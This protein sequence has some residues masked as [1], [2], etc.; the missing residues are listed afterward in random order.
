MAFRGHVLITDFSYG[1]VS[2]RWQSRVEGGQ[3]ETE[4]GADIALSDVYQHGCREMTNMLI[5]P[6]GGAIKRLGF[7]QAATPDATFDDVDN[8]GDD[9]RLTR[10]QSTPADF[11][12]VFKDQEVIIYETDQGYPWTVSQTVALPYLLT[13]LAQL[14]FVQIRESLIL[15]QP[16]FRPR[17][18]TLLDNGTFVLK[19]TDDRFVPPLFSYRDEFSP[20]L[21]AVTFHVVFTITKNRFLIIDVSGVPT[22]SNTTIVSTDISFTTKQLTDALTNTPSVNPSSV[23]VVYSGVNLEWDITYEFFST[24]GNGTGTLN[25]GIQNPGETEDAVVTLTT[26]GASGGEDLWSGPFLVS[27]N[28]VFYQCLQPHRSTSANEPGTGGGAAFWL[29][30][31]ASVPTDQDYTV[32][33]DV[34]E[35]DESYSVGDRG[36]PRIGTFHEQRLILDGGPTVP[37]AVA[38]SKVG[39]TDVLNFQ[40]GPT[41]ADAF[42]YL[43]ASETGLANQWFASQRKLFVGT[44]RGTY[45][46]QAIPLTPTNVFFERNSMHASARQHA[47][48]VAG[49]IYHLQGNR[50]ILRKVQFSEDLQLWTARD[51]ATF[52]EHLLEDKKGVKDWTYVDEPDA[53]V[54]CVRQDGALLSFSYQPNYGITA[55]ARHS[56]SDPVIETAVFDD[57]ISDRTAIMTKR[58]QWDNVAQLWKYRPQVEV[59]ELTSRNL[60]EFDA[61]IFDE[62]TGDPKRSDWDVFVTPTNEQTSHL[63]AY[64]TF[65]GDGGT[66]FTDSRFANR[67]VGVVED[68]IYLGQF[69][70]DANGTITLSAPS[71]NGSNIFIGY[72]YTAKCTPNRYELMS[73]QGSSQSQKSRWTK[74]VLRLFASNM[75]LI[76][77][78]RAR[79]RSQD[80]NYDT[81]SSLFTG[82]VYLVNYGSDGRLTIEMDVPLPFHMTGIFGLLSVEEG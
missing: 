77:G 22:S 61:Q 74:P 8:E 73:G 2:P 70:A 81:A 75:P 27:H 33:P 64:A 37:N 36:W 40:L 35:V 21:A 42:I 79:E 62:L 57:G 76:N 41:D 1:E 10:F 78:E 45:V 25:I 13:D 38:G 48:A 19:T 15:I 5:M 26:A 46:Q 50:R 72:E 60:L 43:I 30:V 24:A 16:T 18:L 53:T 82:D 80:D 54:F 17:L 28:A 11:F 4:R 51:I 58:R 31:G 34:W 14:E 68:G 7:R 63:D 56:V 9:Y 66:T 6:Q 32:D 23:V 65:T 29:D 44:T 67:T 20:P 47:L 69:L 59:L 3:V 55:W 12:M 49:E 39:R 71:I 52:A